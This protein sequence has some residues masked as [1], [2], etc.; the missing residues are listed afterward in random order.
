MH[1]RELL[2]IAEHEERERQL[3]RAFSP[4]TELVEISGCELQ[5]LTILCNLTLKRADVDDVLAIATAKQ[6]L[7]DPR[8][9]E[10]CLNEVTWYHTHN[11]KYPDT[12]VSHQRLLL[13]PP[14]RVPGVVTSSDVPR[15]LGWSHNSTECNRAKLFCSAFMM[16][17]VVTCLAQQII[18]NSSRWLTRL[19]QRGLPAAS[20][21]HLVERLIESL[22]EISVPDEISPY[23]KQV[24][25]FDG[26]VYRA[27]TP[28]VSHSLQSQIQHLAIKRRIRAAVTEL[29]HPSSVGD[30]AASLGGRVRVMSY[31]PPVYTS[32]HQGLSSARRNKIRQ[33]GSVFDKRAL[34]SRQ[35]IY[36]L[37]QLGGSCRYQTLRERR[38]SRVRALRVVRNA[39]AQWLAP[40]MEWRD[41]VESQGRG[42]SG[43]GEG[44]EKEL[45]E[46]PPRLLPGLLAQLSAHLQEELQQ[47]AKTRA[48]AYHPELFAPLRNQIKWLLEQLGKEDDEPGEPQSNRL[49]Y[50]HLS[51]LRVFDAQALSSP[52]VAGIPS[53]SALWGLGHHFE[54]RLAQ[55]LGRSVRVVSMA[56]HIGQYS[57]VSGKK[58]P[59]P[60][61]LRTLKQ[62]SDIKRP[63]IIDTRLCDLTMNMV[64]KLVTHENDDPLSDADIP[65]IQAAFPSRFAGG[66]LQPPCLYEKA[67]W[68]SLY[69]SAQELFEP[70]SRLPRGGC[71][72]Y[73]M[74]EQ[75]SS[76]DELLEAMQAKPSYRPVTV[77]Y[78]AL[79][80]GREREGSLETEHCYAEP[81]IGLADCVGPIEVRLAG[82]KAFLANAFW[83]MEVDG[84]AM[85]VKKAPLLE[86]FYETRQAP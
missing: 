48:F 16:D 50:L 73:P 28:V 80:D 6:A 72:I 33:G 22:P 81:A 83:H 27:V 34:R 53:L 54:R 61:I 2:A 78:V 65:S 10:R 15:L 85:L 19:A 31:P 36:S 30:L 13:P 51:N 44:I 46:T 64:L 59:E 41:D 52:Y 8:H 17:G 39:L 25:I 86:P 63:G 74:T 11:V 43:L 69:S 42:E 70:L 5:A 26:R 66:T 62:G 67:H 40:L 57:S 49:S 35:F 14:K 4:A 82:M 1:L 3:R 24:R 45:L 12:R 18:Q 29:A 55:L 76:V 9:F 32:M 38:R 68:C 47:S 75:V 23:S 20:R 56:W 77:G 21:K 37:S 7:S 60:S 79:E 84:R 58:L 71:W